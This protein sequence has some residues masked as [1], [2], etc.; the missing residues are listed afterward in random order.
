M[1]AKKAKRKVAATQRKNPKTEC[2][3][4]YWA[5]LCREGRVAEMELSLA[6]NVEDIH[7]RVDRGE[8]DAR[9]KSLGATPRQVAAGAVVEMCR[10]AFEVQREVHEV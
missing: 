10:E 1:P 2:W 4:T 3:R 9:A 8:F 7:E 5:K 6:Q